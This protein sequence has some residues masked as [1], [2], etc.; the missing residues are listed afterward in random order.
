MKYFK[1][2]IPI[3]IFFA[4]EK[5]EDV[6]DLDIST[7]DLHKIFYGNSYYRIK[8][9]KSKK[10]DFKFNLSKPNHYLKL[11]SN[12][13]IEGFNSLILS[14]DSF[15]FFINEARDYPIFHNQIKFNNYIKKD[16]FLL[17]SFSLENFELIGLRNTNY[18]QTNREGD[19]LSYFNLL[20]NKNETIF[21]LVFYQKSINDL[22]ELENQGL[23][24]TSISSLYF[25]QN[26]FTNKYS[27][28]PDLEFFTKQKNSIISNLINKLNV[29]IK[30]DEENKIYN[31]YLITSDTIIDKDLII[32][33][34]KFRI[35]NNSD[36]I[37]KNG[38]KLVIDESVIDVS[39]KKNDSIRIIGLDNN[40]IL[41]RNCEKVDF[42]FCNVEG[43]SGFTSFDINLPSSITFYNSNVIITNSLFQSNVA[44]DDFINFFYS[45][46]IIDNSNFE[47]VKS[48][49]I[50]S[51]FS[52][53][54]ISNSNFKFIGND[55]IDF[56][57]SNASL[58]DLKFYNINDKAISI[59]ENSNI[60]VDNLKIFDSEIGIVVKDGSSIITKNI[61]FENNKVNYCSFIKKNFY[62]Y[63]KLTICDSILIG[64][65]LIEEN[66]ILET[67]NKYITVEKL[68]NVEDLL[69]GNLYGKSSE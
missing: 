30:K 10:K 31:R 21:D 32:K 58:F 56:S 29:E 67:S 51:D 4:C 9:I 41:I 6:L 14:D 38:A 25:I 19:L 40:S 13:K 64:T 27:I 49:A 1:L 34:S 69:Y 48:D 36:L 3:L 60:D 42:S 23:Y 20:D 39:G 52:A 63:P 61:L 22:I 28:I 53:G 33:N 46:F 8:G 24:P 47:N 54:T 65:N 68:K 17:P 16:F 11:E 62:D 5:K 12:F 26:P 55:A 37:L 2:F 43:L 15:N 7:K 18:Y 44:G 35:L 57:G 50:D 66:T 45:D 59:G